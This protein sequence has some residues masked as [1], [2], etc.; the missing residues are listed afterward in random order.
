MITVCY[1]I[2]LN[3]RQTESL[4]PKRGLRQGDPLLTYLF[5]LCANVLF[6]ILFSMEDHKL[7]QGVK[8]SK[9]ALRFNHLFYVDDLI[10]FFFQSYY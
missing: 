8:I 10:V 2:L 4:F 5:I 3:G 9:Q 1:R 7:I 6:K